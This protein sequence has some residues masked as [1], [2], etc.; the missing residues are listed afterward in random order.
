MS[1]LHIEGYCSMFDFEGFD[2]DGDLKIY[3]QRGFY[4][5]NNYI[6]KKAVTKLRDFLTEILEEN[7]N[8]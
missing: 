4:G 7:G 2:K 3:Y 1:E 6:N 5:T 8:S